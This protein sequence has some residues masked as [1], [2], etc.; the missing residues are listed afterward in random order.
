MKLLLCTKCGDVR[1][2][3]MTRWTRCHCRQSRGRYRTEIHAEVA[4]PRA[5]LLGFHN[6]SLRAAVQLE[7]ADRAAGIARDLGHVFEAFVIPFSSPHVRTLEP[8]RR[9]NA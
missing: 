7:A 3:R 5:M 4:G 2:L 8:R 6:A 9:K 1:A